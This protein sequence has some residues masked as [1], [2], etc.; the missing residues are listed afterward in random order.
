MA[1]H[2]KSE[3]EDQ[4]MIGDLSIIERLWHC[5]NFVMLILFTNVSVITPSPQ[6]SGIGTGALVG[7]IIGAI[8][9]ATTLSAIVSLL[10]L[11]KR[12]KDNRAISKRRRC[13]FNPFI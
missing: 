2:L 13:K 11:R 6:K 4:I 8:A 10:I 3:N 9:V 12:L 1:Q 5:I 7:I